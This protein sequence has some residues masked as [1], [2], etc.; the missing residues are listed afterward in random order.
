VEIKELSARTLSA[1]S[2]RVVGTVSTCRA[3]IHDIFRETR[4]TSGRQEGAVRRGWLAIEGR[5]R[6]LELQERSSPRLPSEPELL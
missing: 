4:S 6:A 3:N 5:S 1:A 2:K